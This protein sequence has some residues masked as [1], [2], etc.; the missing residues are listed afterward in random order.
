MILAHFLDEGGTRRRC[1]QRLANAHRARRILHV[2]DRR[3][4]LRRYFLTDVWAGE[5]VAPPMSNGTTKFCR[6]IS[7]ATFT[8]SSS[9]GVMSPDKTDEN[10]RSRASPSRGSSRTE[11]MTP[12]SM[13]SKLLQLEN[14]ADDVLAESCT[15]P[16]TVAIT[17]AAGSAALASLFPFLDVGNEMRHGSLHHARALHY[18][19][20][21][22]FSP[23]RTGHRRH[24]CRP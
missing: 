12:R 15:S 21:K 23:T 9:D 18:L 20:E 8:I 22:H 13:T 16:F 14:D 11:T 5:V 24:S 3:T 10:P 4:V 7:F 19:R 2:D 6:C 1:L 17:H